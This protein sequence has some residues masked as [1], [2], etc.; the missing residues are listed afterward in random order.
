[1]GLSELVFLEVVKIKNFG[2]LASLDSY[3]KSDI[4]DFPCGVCEKG[5]SFN[6]T[7]F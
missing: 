1:M 4:L 2:T 5:T 3:S 7:G 6:I